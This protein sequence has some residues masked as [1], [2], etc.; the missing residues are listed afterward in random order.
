MSSVLRAH[1]RY[2]FLSGGLIALVLLLLASSTSPD[3]LKKV[4]LSALGSK[5]GE[6]GGDWTAPTLKERLGRAESLW[7]DSV[8]RRYA[9]YPR[10]FGSST[11]RIQILRPIASTRL[12]LASSTRLS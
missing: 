6:G 2:A 4:G 8:K 5:G 10:F 12:N 1:P 3:S 7:E 11:R 9:I